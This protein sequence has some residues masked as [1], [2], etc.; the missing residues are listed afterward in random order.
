MKLFLSK[1]SLRMFT[2]VNRFIRFNF[3]A[4]SS[5]SESAAKCARDRR[6]SGGAVRERRAEHARPVA[7][8]S[9]RSAG[10]DLPRKVAPRAQP[11][12][13]QSGDRLQPA[14]DVLHRSVAS[15]SEQQQL[16]AASS[17]AETPYQSPD[18]RL[19]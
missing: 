2:N 12:A 14:A 19:E 13:Q 16:G 11:F 6:A 1:N 18:T 17:A 5:N 10:R 7:Q 3:P 8:Q 15:G 9:H 4:M